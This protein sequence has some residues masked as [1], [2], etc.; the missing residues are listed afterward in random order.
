M[1]NAH[2]PPRPIPPPQAVTG[3]GF[4]TT[5]NSTG[6]TLTIEP[7]ASIADI[8]AI[9]SEWEALD[10]RVNPRTPFSSPTWNM[11]WW[12]HFQKNSLLISDELLVL[13][14]RL[15]SRQ[16]VAVAPLFRR[17]IPAFFPFHARFVQFFG[18]DSSITEVRGIVCAPEMEA[19]VYTA[20]EN[21][22]ES[23]TIGWDLLRWDGIKNLE[24]M[25]S[26]SRTKGPTSRLPNYYIRLP[27]HWGVL[28]KRLSGKF[29]R[30]MRK[31][32]EIFD[33]DGHTYTF[34]CIDNETDMPSGLATFFALHQMRAHVHGMEYR[35]PDRFA[36]PRNKNFISA[37]MAAMTSR[38]CGRIF[39]IRVKDVAIASQTAFLLGNELWLYS[40]G[41]DPEWRRYGI[42][43][44]LIAEI[45]KW[46]IS[47]QLAVVNLSCG[48]DL[49]KLRWEPSEIFFHG[50]LQPKSHLRGRLFMS[51]YRLKGQ[52]GDGLKWILGYRS[53]QIRP[54]EE[55]T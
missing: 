8:A 22:L 38:G 23:A 2:P 32:R 27:K 4:R 18:A 26:H 24:A 28:E 3:A 25:A 6:M 10:A 45:L 51:A 21:Y 46:S 40:S 1:E 49:G 53:G 15:P 33:K 31:R 12:R 13:A 43:T 36:D 35:H 20:L 44:V 34:H 29:K 47:S 48:Q 19:E 16:L 17:R 30:N 54:E 37:Y 7:L 52:L 42:M 50:F 5:G 9:S 11:L 39:E 41:Y 14:F 55:S